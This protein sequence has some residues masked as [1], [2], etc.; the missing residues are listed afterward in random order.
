MSQQYNTLE[1]LFWSHI[2]KGN[3]CWEWNDG[4]TNGDYGRA[5]Y[6]GKC[7]LASRIAW[8][9]TYGALPNNRIQVCHHC[10][11]P[12]CCR[13]DHL[14]L[15]TNKD[16]CHDAMRKGRTTKGRKRDPRSVELTAASR[17]GTHL[18]IE[19]RANI[20]RALKGRKT[21]PCTAERRAKLS[22]INKGKILSP[23]HRAKISASLL[24][25]RAR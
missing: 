13:P 1:H 23:E 12:P 4:N 9:L 7:Q 2:K 10:D 24:A 15:G 8:Q 20:A 25:R 6:N 11:N 22:A 21:G 17:R 19:H 5:R 16:N 18:T 3:G 14:F